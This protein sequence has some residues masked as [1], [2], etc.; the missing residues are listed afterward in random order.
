MKPAY[1]AAKF[2]FIIA[3][4][5]LVLS[6]APVWADQVEYH[7]NNREKRCSITKQSLS[8]SVYCI[9]DNTNWQCSDH[10][11]KI[12][13]ENSSQVKENIDKMSWNNPAMVCFKLC[14]TCSSGWKKYEGGG[15][16]F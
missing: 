8:A 14:G 13:C 12:E 1:T 7:C 3:S 4:A 6:V 16:T 11:D 10:F 2:L 5:L 15:S 9:P